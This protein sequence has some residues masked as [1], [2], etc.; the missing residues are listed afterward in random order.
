MLLS[1]LFSLYSVSNLGMYG[2]REFTAIINPPQAAILAVGGIKSVP[3]VT[4]NDDEGVA[5]IMTVTLSHDCRVI[6]YE[7]AAKWLT[8]FKS[9]LESPSIL[10]LL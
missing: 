4:D 1:L 9:F 2:I 7:L 6:D 10:G 8:V 5:K 3:W